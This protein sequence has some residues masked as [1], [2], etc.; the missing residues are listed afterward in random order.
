[1]IRITNLD[2]E[3][4]D[5]LLWRLDKPLTFGTGIGLVSV[6]KN[7]ITDGASCP[8][9]LWTL[10]SPMSGPQAEAAVLH[11]FLYSKDSNNICNVSRKLA[12]Q[13]FYDAMVSNGTGKAR[14]KAIYWGV[15]AGGS[16][17]YKSCFSIEKVKE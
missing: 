17:S 2:T 9:I 1:M 16:G 13:L 12:D 6:P 3:K 14:A 10:C 15:R 5:H 8:R 7:F 4:I 11:D